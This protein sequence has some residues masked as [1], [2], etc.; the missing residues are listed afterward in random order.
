MDDHL[1]S[2]LHLGRWWGVRLRLHYLSVVFGL[3]L[4]Y[5]LWATTPAAARSD[6]LISGVVALGVLAACVLLHQMGHILVARQWGL[7]PGEMTICPWGEC[8]RWPMVDDPRRELVVLAAGPVTNL[9]GSLLSLVVLLALGRRSLV[10]LFVPNQLVFHSGALH[11]APLAQCALW[12]NWC[13][14]LVN[15][16]PAFP[17]DGGR[18]LQAAV[19]RLWPQ[20]GNAEAFLTVAR[21]GRLTAL[22][23]LL[24]AI[25]VGSYPLAPQLPA[26]LALGLL[27]SLIFFFS[28]ADLMPTEA[29]DEGDETTLGYDFSAGY[30]SLE[31]SVQKTSTNTQTGMVRQWILRRR[32]E[33][34]R[35]RRQREM[36]EDGKVDQILQR[37][38]HF[39]LGSLSRAE[40]R[41]LRRAG[42]RYRVKGD[43]PS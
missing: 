16:L 30:T 37:V 12:I 34:K 42:E 17:F 10:E 19:L 14:M 3:V 6:A 1:P 7:A 4:L 35:L 39:G 28:N 22:G 33:R 24:A 38:H 32:A 20:A 31:Q 18:M 23:L 9:A 11:P 25:L 5:G 29:D 15:F 40:R 2:S 26:W 21:L 27:S 41:L 36:H 13:V 43:D 8:R